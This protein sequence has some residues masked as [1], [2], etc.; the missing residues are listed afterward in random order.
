MALLDMMQ[1]VCNEVGLP[2]PASV[3]TST[4]RQVIQLLATAHRVLNDLKQVPWAELERSC[5][6]T[7]V[8]GQEAY[9]LPADFDSALFETQWNVDK[10]WPLFGP[11]TSTE[12]ATIKNSGIA[13][14]ISQR[15]RLKGYASKK[16]FIDP[17]PTSSEAGQVV[18]FYYQSKNIVRPRIWEASQL[19]TAGSYT[20]YDGNY[21]STTL[22][23]TT[24]STAPTHSTGSVSDGG[25]TWTFYDEPYAKFLADTDVCIVDEYLV[26]VGVQYN[27]LASKGLP[28]AHLEQKYNRDLRSTQPK[29]PGA[30]VLDLASREGDEYLPRVQIPETGYGT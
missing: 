13:P 3:A 6:L 16:F 30:P 9:E 1:A 21:Y 4:E 24:G 8:D 18:T 23:G 25:V 22:G 14:A 15:F 20:F 17:V 7:L 12:W 5:E 19:Y 28:Y 26:G 10:T 29:L 11:Y 2:E 27:Y